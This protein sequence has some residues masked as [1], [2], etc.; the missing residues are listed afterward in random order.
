MRLRANMKLKVQDDGEK[1]PWRL[2]YILIRLMDNMTVNSNNNVSTPNDR[3][4]T[5]RIGN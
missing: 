4:T 2:A 3:I 5:C 1:T